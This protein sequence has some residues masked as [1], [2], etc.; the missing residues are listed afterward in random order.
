MRSSFE[1]KIGIAL[2]D[3]N[4]KCD[5]EEGK[6]M[7]L[8]FM[9]KVQNGC[10]ISYTENGF[11]DSMKVMTKSDKPNKLGREFM[12]HMISSSSNQRPVAFNLMEKYRS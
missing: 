5:V 2:A 10:Y 4:W 3:W 6:L 12:M 8:E 9:V 7:L 11:L 1:N